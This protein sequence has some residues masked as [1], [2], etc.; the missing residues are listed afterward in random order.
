[1]VP[2]NSSTVAQL[3]SGIRVPKYDRRNVR[4]GI[5]HFGVGNFFRVHQAVYVDDC[6]HM[7]GNE[8]WGIVGVGLTNG[9]G[10]REKADAFRAQDCLYS[11]TEF[12]TDGSPA[13][14]VIGAVIDYLHAPSDPEAVLARLAHPDTRIVTMT[15]TE[16]GY[17]IDE[18]S[19]R[20]MLETSEVAGDLRGGPPRTA[21]GFL[22]EGLARRR[23]AGLEGFTIASCDNLRGSGDTIRTAVMAFAHAR[24]RNLADW[25]EQ[26][27]DFPNS[28]VDRLAPQISDRQRAALNEGTGLDDRVPVLT[29]SF[30]QWVVED[31]FRSG[32]PP[33]ETAGVEFRDNVG[34]YLALK[35]R[36]INAPHVFLSYPGLLIG[37][38]IVADALAD[39][40]LVDLVEAFLAKDAIPNTK[41]PP[42]TSIDEFAARFVPRFANPSIADQLLRVAG[43]GAAK[44]PTFHGGIVRALMDRGADM[45]R[46]AFLMAC[47]GRY[48]RFSFDDTIVDDRGNR[49]EPFEP[50]LTAADWDKVRGADP[51]GVLAIQALKP[52][53]LST[54]AEFLSRFEHSARLLAVDGARAAVKDVLS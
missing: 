35:G 9:P 22:V 46:E 2:L 21:F 33:L 50:N 16:G 8:K 32:R 31:R 48:L 45:R 40:L 36:L 14:R 4:P 3:D 6:L 18:A 44:L 20:F 53:G 1:M 10:A 23:A 47:Y 30:T 39:P 26:H 12:A 38:R 49:F 17:N 7:P 42:G 25:I 29:E 43:D 13:F 28:M 51:Q 52:L 37:Y 5:V 54:N 27:V 41:G 19:G 11:L 34:E 24:D 15:I